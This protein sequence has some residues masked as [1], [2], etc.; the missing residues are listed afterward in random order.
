VGAQRPPSLRV[1]RMQSGDRDCATKFIGY[2]YPH[3]V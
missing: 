1:S 2:T 3:C